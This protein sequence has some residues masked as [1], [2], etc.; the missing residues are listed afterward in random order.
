M[1][2]EQWLPVAVIYGKVNLY[3]NKLLKFKGSD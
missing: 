3:L 1:R 2:Y